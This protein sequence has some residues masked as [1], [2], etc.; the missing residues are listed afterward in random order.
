[1]FKPVVICV[2]ACDHNREHG[3]LKWLGSFAS[4]RSY[5]GPMCPRARRLGAGA[6]ITVLQFAPFTRLRSVPGFYALNSVCAR[7]NEQGCNL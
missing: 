5:R 4:Q 7:L 1:M 3:G 6:P 2:I